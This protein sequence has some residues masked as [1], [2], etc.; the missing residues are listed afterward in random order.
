MRIIP[1]AASPQWRDNST[2]IPAH[3]VSEIVVS[4]PTAY[5]GLFNL[6]ISAHFVSEIVVFT[7][8]WYRADHGNIDCRYFNGC[9]NRIK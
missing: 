4:Q 9:R 2:A 7:Q 6:P 1:S 5:A 8:S 3:F